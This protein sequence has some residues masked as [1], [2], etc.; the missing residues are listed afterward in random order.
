MHNEQTE[1]TQVKML[2]EL[3]H[4]ELLRTAL[5]MQNMLGVSLFDREF[6]PMRPTIRDQAWRYGADSSNELRNIMMRTLR[7]MTT[8]VHTGG[9]LP[10]EGPPP[11]EFM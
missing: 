3:S 5:L 11:L 6:A 7:S 1:Q 2:A 10:R 8:R 9:G 4:E